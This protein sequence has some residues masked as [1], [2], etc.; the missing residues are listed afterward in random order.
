MPSM[1]LAYVSDYSPSA[2][3]AWAV[4]RRDLA[5][6]R[7]V[8]DRAFWEKQPLVPDWFHLLGALLHN[9]KPMVRL[10]VAHGADWTPR[11]ARCLQEVFAKEWPEFKSTLRGCGLTTDFG[12]LPA[13]ADPQLRDEMMDRLLAEPQTEKRFAALCAAGAAGSFLSQAFNRQQSEKRFGRMHGADL[14]KPDNFSAFV[15]AHQKGL[16]RISNDW[17][18]KNLLDCLQRHYKNGEVPETV[19][20]G[21]QVIKAHGAVFKFARDRRSFP[22]HDYLG[23][24]EPGLAKV[25]LDTGILRP[26]DFDIPFLAT[27]LHPP[28][29]VGKYWE[30][31]FQ[32]SLEQIYPEKLIPLRGKI[33]S[34]HACFKSPAAYLRSPSGPKAEG[35]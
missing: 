24:K 6:A 7:D 1:A 8:F 23:K 18:G 30:F 15:D 12:D 33:A 4:D 17:Q 13:A 25:L 29:Y 31:F 35:P 26:E 2:Y 27:R 3:L 16:Y 32:V 5:L 10:L 11:Q 34:Y 21:L 28:H 22:G 14:L 19:R 9:D 20:R